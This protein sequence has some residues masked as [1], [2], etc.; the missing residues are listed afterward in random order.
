MSAGLNTGV[1]VSGAEHRRARLNIGVFVWHG[2]HSQPQD[3]S[4]ATPRMSC[5]SLCHCL[6]RCPGF[7]WS[8]LKHLR[9]FRNQ[10]ELLVPIIQSIIACCSGLAEKVKCTNEHRP[11]CI[12][13]NVLKAQ[14]P[15][16]FKTMVLFILSPLLKNMP[17]VHGGS[18]DSRSSCEM[19]ALW[20]QVNRGEACRL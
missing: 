13:Q 19:A 4:K 20:V 5:L 18:A 11:Y 1:Y 7:G 12:F 16:S 3:R 9:L 15:H 10:L 6:C 8:L 17:F 14:P 2:C